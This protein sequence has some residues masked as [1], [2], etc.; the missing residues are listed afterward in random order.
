M[1]LITSPDG[2]HVAGL[3]IQFKAAELLNINDG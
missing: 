3:R 1:P 2:C